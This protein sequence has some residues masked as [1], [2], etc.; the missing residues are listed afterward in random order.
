MRL[1]KKCPRLSTSQMTKLKFKSSQ[2]KDK[3]TFFPPPPLLSPWFFRNK[4]KEKHLFI[5]FISLKFPKRR[6]THLFHENMHSMIKATVLFKTTTTK[7]ILSLLCLQTVLSLGNY[8]QK[9]LNTSK[10]PESTEHSLG[11]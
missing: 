11:I 2:F 9:I 8:L 5:T 4:T 10:A 1:R 3:V 6:I 7:K